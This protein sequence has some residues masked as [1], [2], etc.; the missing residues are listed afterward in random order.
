MLSTQVTAVFLKFLKGRLRAGRLFFKPKSTGP[1]SFTGNRSCSLLAAI[2][3]SSAVAALLLCLAHLGSFQTMEVK[4]FDLL[5]RLSARIFNGQAQ[6]KAADSPVVIVAI[7]EADIQV[8]NRWPLSDLVFA[9]LLARLQQSSP[10]VIGLDIYRDVPHD[11]GSEALTRQLQRENVVAIKKLGLDEELEVQPPPHVPEQRVGFNDFVIDPDGVIRRNFMFAALGDQR[12]YSF[13]LRLAGQF[14]APKGIDITP[15]S[16]AIVVGPT[17]FE[18]IGANAGGYQTIDAVGYQVLMRYRPPESFAR[19]LTLTQVL[20][21]DFD[22]DW[23]RDKVVLIGTTAP[24]EK[25]LFYT[26]FSA[27]KAQEVMTPGVV[28]HAQMTY[29]VLSAVL[30]QRLLLSVWPQPGEWAWAWLWSLMGGVITWRFRHPQVVILAL[31]AGFGGLLA[32]T[33]GLFIQAVWVPFALPATALTVS[34]ISVIVYKEF[35]KTFYDFVTGLPNRTLLIQELEKLLYQTSRTPH[36]T[37]AVILLS[38]DKFTAFTESFGLQAS[39][40]LLR[41]TAKRLRQSLPPTAKLAHITSDEFVILLGAIVHPSEAVDIAKGLSQQ[42]SKLV[43]LNGQRMFPT[44]SS[45]IAYSVRH[46]LNGQP[47]PRYLDVSQIPSAEGLLRNAQTAISRA[48]EHGRRGHCEVFAKDMRAQTTYRVGLETDLRDALDRQEFELYYQPLI[49][50]ETMTLSGFE[51]LIRWHHPQKGLMS[52]GSFIS[53][54]EDTGLIIPIGQWVMEAACAQLQKWH[55]QFA[56]TAPFVSV[57]ISGRQFAQPDLVEH[58]SRILLRTGLKP[59]TLKLELT[60][61]VV[62]D[63]VE[64]SIKVLLSLKALQL[65]LGIDDFGTGYSSLSYLHRFPLD[66]L[67]IDRSFVMRM[68]SPGST[69]ELV[70]TIVALG[71]NLGMDVVAEGIETDAQ[72]KQLRAL[73]CEYGQGYFFSKP[74]PAFAAEALLAK[75]PDW[76]VGSS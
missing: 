44:V 68:E 11:P 38:I 8:Q 7:T 24:S 67:K 4:S 41:L 57:N 42:I 26:P 61:S 9:R 75:A 15:E 51:A 22:P 50:L 55:R 2:A 52:P 47:V 14:L 60:E 59:S 54:A 13:S 62:M 71:H 53:I 76:S 70:R 33:G 17:R 3:L 27:A 28:I 65:T 36:T 39:D 69:G 10:S 45:G 19:V 74:I 49:S 63:R 31:I 72:S 34:G 35:R 16:Q 23:I 25:D 32:M 66:T 64:E 43:K 20:Q 1:G 46:S 21:G 6:S 56:D 40:H 37:V 5:T 29:Q 18:R 58:V 48:K 73:R 30:E 12:Y